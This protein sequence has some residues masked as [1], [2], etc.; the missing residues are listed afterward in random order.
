M[1]R[2]GTLRASQH[3]LGNVIN[4]ECPG[5][6]GLLQID[7]KILRHQIDKTGVVLQFFKVRHP[8]SFPCRHGRNGTGAK[9]ARL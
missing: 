3:S 2:I 1:A 6:R 5:N 7:T 9:A 8:R 4:L